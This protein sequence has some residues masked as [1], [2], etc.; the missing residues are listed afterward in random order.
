MGRWLAVAAIV[1]AA[2]LAYA[3][4]LSAPL[5][6]DD[7]PAIVD[8]PSIR[9]LSTALSPPRDGRGVTGRPL[10]NLSLALNYAVHGERVRGYHLVN[11]AIH[12]LA[13]LALFGVARRTFRQAALRARFGGA[14][15]PLA[16]AVGVLWTLH[17]LQT[18]SVTC[19]AQRTESLAALCYLATLYGF[20]RSAKAGASVGWQIFAVAACAAG[21]A[22][23]ETMVTAPLVV[24]VY[25]RTFVAGTFVAAWRRRKTQYLALAATWLLL[26][27][28]VLAQGGS[29]GNAEGEALGPTI[30]AYLLTQCRALP[31]YFALAAWPHPLVLDYDTRLVTNLADVWLPGLGLIGLLG[32]TIC[33]LQRSPTVGFLGAWLFLILAPSSSV[34][35][36]LPQPVAEHRMYLPLAALIAGAVLAVYR[37]AGRRSFVLFAAAAVS[38]GI[39]TARRNADYRSA[40]MIWR[41]TV[42][43]QP[44]NARAHFYLG[45]A[46][47]S[48]GR[49][50]AALA[51]YRAALNRHPQY[52]DAHAALG[53]LLGEAGQLEEAIQH[54]ALATRLKPTLRDAP[55]N[56][57]LYLSLAG[58]G[59]DAVAVLSD[60]LSRQVD[61][62]DAQCWLADAF[63]RLGH[64]G[65]AVPHYAAAVRCSRDP[66][67]AETNW[68]AACLQLNQPREALEHAGRALQLNPD[69]VE[70]HQNLALALVVLGRDA[71]ALPHFEAVLRARPNDPDA[72]DQ[73]ARIRRRNG[74]TR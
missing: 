25:D 2:A 53:R 7:L 67:K 62:G 21:M 35:P 34:V 22:A 14:A 20:I 29:R 71:E 8:N 39:L 3:N 11:L 47:E 9:S 37:V 32:A 23:K 51:S 49:R 64:P 63:V 31:H 16:A 18:E 17:P 13:G 48:A 44:Q 26:A 15:L 30:F 36:L 42:A 10:V 45:Y 50:E 1:L 58:R 6:F 27:W 41:Q 46:L 33:C 28:L 4:T 54:L 19:I 66:T 73:L 68:S 70:A 74:S 38:L 43:D 72:R 5:I 52:A 69:S 59:D 65:R 55:K 56:L 61:D 12:A 57:G 60:F 24:F 40:E